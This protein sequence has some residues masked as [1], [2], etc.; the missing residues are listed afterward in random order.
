MPMSAEP[1]SCM[2]VRT[3]AKSRLIRP[4]IVIRSV[5]PWTPWRRTLS[6]SRKASRM[7]VRR[8]TIES[9][10][11]FGMTISVSTISRRRSMP[12]WAWRWRCAPSKR[13]RARDDADGERADLVLG[14]L[15]DHRRGAGAGAAALAGG[16][17]DHVG[18]LE[19]LLDVV[20]RLGRGALADLRVGAR[21]EP[22]G[23]VV[24]DVQLDVGVRHLERLGVGVAGDELHAG[25]AGVDHPVDGVGSAA[26]D[27]DDL[28]HCEIAAC[29]HKFLSG[30]R[31]RVERFPALAW[32]ADSSTLRAISF[33]MSKGGTSARSLADPANSR[34]K[35]ENWPILTLRLRVVGRVVERA[36]APAR[37]ARRRPR[38]PASGRA[39]RGRWPPPRRTRRAPGRPPSTCA[40]ASSAEPKTSSGPLRR[41][42]RHPAR[43]VVEALARARSSVGRGGGD[44]ERRE[45]VAIGDVV[46]GERAP[47]STTGRSSARTPSSSSPPPVAGT[48]R[49]AGLRR[50][51]RARARPPRCCRSCGK[52]AWMRGRRRERT[53]RPHSAAR[54]AS[55]CSVLIPFAAV[56][57]RL[58]RPGPPPRSRCRSP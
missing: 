41:S 23:E 47:A 25:E 11:S 32:G 9:S 18:A 55:T 28:D 48:L 44:L 49:A 4:G 10:R 42:R 20:A 57:E 24:A 52:S 5:M 40:R 33:P 6:A 17:E 12:S 19:R 51:R 26:A 45:R 16:D 38:R 29:F 8:S 50:S 39:G 27:A 21:A 2:I 58:A 37:S 35:V 56:S 46:A 7:L 54:R 13:E 36:S 22:L 43:A 3:S 14:D 1:A 34:P 31:V 15:G 30:P 53:A